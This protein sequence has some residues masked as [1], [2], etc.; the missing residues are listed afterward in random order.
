MEGMKT[1]LYF[2]RRE[3]NQE[4]LMC[5]LEKKYGEKRERKYPERCLNSSQNVSPSI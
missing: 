4:T 2:W 5:F 3:K 1:S